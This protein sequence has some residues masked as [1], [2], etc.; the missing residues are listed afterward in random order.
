MSRPPTSL[1]GY[2]RD[3]AH[4]SRLATSAIK[5]FALH[6]PESLTIEQKRAVG[7][8]E[9]YLV[10]DQ[11]DLAL[12]NF[13]GALL[14]CWS[15]FEPSTDLLTI[16]WGDETLHTGSANA[17]GRSVATYFDVHRTEQGLEMDPAWSEL[18]SDLA[19]EN[20]R[21]IRGTSALAGQDEGSVS[22][23]S[24][25]SVEEL[26]TEA[27]GSPLDPGR[28]RMNMWIDGT[29]PF[30]E[31]TWIGKQVSVGSV[32]LEATNWSTRCLM[33]QRRSGDDGRR[34][35][36]LKM[37][38]RRRGVHR[39]EAGQGLRMGIYLRVVRPGTICLGDPVQVRD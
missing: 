4:I 3:T 20:V 7:D 31:D 34:L 36:T 17:T 10:D 24:T 13:S 5:G 26:G 6:Y 28:F 39:T 25:S 2:R 9:F 11:G 23:V 22:L 15:T 27:D 19:K 38:V 21:L 30:V 18:I 12:A 29:E 16:G 35:E 32:L 37:I 1:V 14:H 8:R 33:T